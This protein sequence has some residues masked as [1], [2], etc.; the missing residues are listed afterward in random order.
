MTHI[1]SLIQAEIMRTGP[2]RARTVRDRSHVAAM[3]RT[4][5]A[6]REAQRTGAERNA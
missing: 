3:L 5:R 4:R 6:L 2:V 1:P